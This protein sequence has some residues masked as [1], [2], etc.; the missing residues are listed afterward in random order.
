MRE[1]VRQ[2]VP[3]PRPPLG[4][5]KGAL[6]GQGYGP[7]LTYLVCFPWILLLGHATPSSEKPHRLAVCLHRCTRSPQSPNRT[8]EE[9]HLRHPPLAAPSQ[10]RKL[11]YFGVHSGVPRGRCVAPL[12]WICFLSGGLQSRVPQTSDILPFAE[13]SLAR[14]LWEFSP[15]AWGQVF[16]MET[17]LVPSWPGH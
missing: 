9:L 11:H 2:R 12:F 17:S 7:E 10:H 3:S 1:V 16:Q 13:I 15:E 4:L 6:L 5:E 8:G 14:A